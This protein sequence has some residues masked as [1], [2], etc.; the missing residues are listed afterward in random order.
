MQR[1]RERKLEN[2]AVDDVADEVEDGVGDQIGDDPPPYVEK[3]G[4]A[5]EPSP[6]NADASAERDGGGEGLDAVRKRLH[7]RLGKSGGRRDRSDDALRGDE[8]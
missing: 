8:L 2:V 6:P 7:E 4:D 1:A 5:E 3:E